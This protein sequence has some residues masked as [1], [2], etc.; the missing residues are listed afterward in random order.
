MHHS[1]LFLTRSGPARPAPRGS[2][3]PL[4]APGL[5]ALL[6]LVLGLLAPAVP[7]L[8]ATDFRDLDAVLVRNVRNGYVDYDGIRADPAFERSIATLA[9]TDPV[10]L[11]TPAERLAF[12]VNAYNAFAIQGILDGLSPATLLGRN[13]FFKRRTFRLMGRDIT[14]QDLEHEEIIP[15]GGPRLHFALVC[16]SLSCPR[17][18]NRAWQGADLD[19]RLD[20]AARQFINDGTRNRFDPGRRIAFVSRIFDWYRKDFAAEAGSV[21]QYLA[22]YVDDPAAAEILRRDGFELRYVDYDWD[23]NGSYRNRSGQGPAPAAR[24]RTP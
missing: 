21:Q 3:L 22:R 24:E 18:A 17:L 15:A 7:V 9:T 16:A 1:P 13:Q 5:L 23:L 12:L 8:A 14:L 11:E 2:S 20:D 4:P 6:L 10:L 19:Q